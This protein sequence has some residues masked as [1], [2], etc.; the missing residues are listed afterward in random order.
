VPY[1]PVV[2]AV[3][4]Q[5]ARAAQIIIQEPEKAQETLP[6]WNAALFCSFAL[7]D[8]KDEQKREL[9]EKYMFGDEFKKI[10]FNTSRR[11]R[12]FAKFNYHLSGGAYSSPPHSIMIKECDD[13]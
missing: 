2:R 8:F 7:R 12:A 13:M 4:M 3:A 10:Q 9:Y 1:H 6:V 11:V 5:G